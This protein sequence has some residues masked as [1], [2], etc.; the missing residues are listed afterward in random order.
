MAKTIPAP[1]ANWENVSIAVLVERV[2]ARDAARLAVQIAHKSEQEAG[3]ALER[4]IHNVE[5][6]I[7]R[8]PDGTVFEVYVEH[9]SLTYRSMHDLYAPVPKGARVVTVVDELTHGKA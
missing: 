5:R 7:Y 6:G 2:R 4:A 8:G 3:A 1:V 9:V